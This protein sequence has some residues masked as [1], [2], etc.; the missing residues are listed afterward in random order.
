M[1][2]NNERKHEASNNKEKSPNGKGLSHI[3]ENWSWLDDYEHSNSS[4]NRET[5]VIEIPIQVKEPEERT[6]SV[7]KFIHMDPNTLESA[8]VFANILLLLFEDIPMAIL[9]ILYIMNEKAGKVEFTPLYLVSFISGLILLGVKL[10]NLGNI[11]KLGDV[12]GKTE[13]ALDQLLML[14]SFQSKVLGRV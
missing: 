2:R 5:E 12:G 1:G 14:R 4:N 8:E 10:N 13:T 6:S 7:V 3:D 9:N 11:K